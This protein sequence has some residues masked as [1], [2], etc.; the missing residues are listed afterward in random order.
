MQFE[1]MGLVGLLRRWRQRPEAA[2]SELSLFSCHQGRFTPFSEQEIAAKR[3]ELRRLSLESYFSV[4][5]EEHSTNNLHL[6]RGG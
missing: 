1:I 6:L 5:P 2:A 3:N 4:F